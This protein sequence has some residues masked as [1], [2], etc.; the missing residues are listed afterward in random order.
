MKL[1]KGDRFIFSSKVIPGNEDKISRIYNK[2]ADQGVEI[3]TAYDK[4]IHCSGHPGQEDLKL[5]LDGTDFTN[6]LPVHGETFFL[7]R[8]KEFVKKNYPNLQVTILN[9]SEEL[10]IHQETDECQLEVD[11]NKQWQ[12]PKLI[13]N[14][15]VEIERS[16]ISQ[17][18]KLA[19]TGS[20]YLTVSSKRANWKCSFLGLPLSLEEKKDWLMDQLFEHSK[21]EG[22][23]KESTD[24]NEIIR[25]KCRNLINAQ[26]G[27]KPVCIIH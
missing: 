5:F 12:D 15:M 24:V 1:R 10:L 22:K 13:L 27:I 18:R 7:H 4:L 23:N 8:H 17:R 20:V 25:I 14:H 26:I 11:V 9:N 21:K 19:A 16:Q 6:Y 2:I 3:V